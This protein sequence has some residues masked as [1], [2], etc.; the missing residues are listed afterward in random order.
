M[1]LILLFSFLMGLM[2][3]IKAEEV[4]KCRGKFSENIYLID[5]IKQRLLIKSS[6]GKTLQ[7]LQNNNN[8][9]YYF[10]V[11]SVSS[12]STFPYKDRIIMNVPYT[13]VEAKLNHNIIFTLMR[14]SIYPNIIAE[15][16]PENVE[17]KESMDYCEIVSD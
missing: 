3:S 4:Y 1:K 14:I 8:Q 16:S 13:K 2:E 11:S 5:V 12:R 17:D 15:Y 6:E 10:Y 9:G 7:D